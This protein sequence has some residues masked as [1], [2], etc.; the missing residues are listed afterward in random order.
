M[1]VGELDKDV[2]EAGSERANFCDG[3]A[4]LQELSAEIV[5]IEM[6]LDE[7]VDGLTENG[8]AADGGE[9]TREAKSSRDFR[10]GDF[11]PQRAGRL[12]VREVT[13]RIRRAVGYEPSVLTVGD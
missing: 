8:G 7:R 11:N 9:V 13:P 2:F 10:W 1:L 3:D 5:E 12:N 4:V 6:V